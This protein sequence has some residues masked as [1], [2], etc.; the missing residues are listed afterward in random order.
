VE[1]PQPRK[2]IAKVGYV[3]ESKGMSFEK[4]REEPPQKCRK[5]RAGVGLVA[6]RDS[7]GE[8]ECTLRVVRG[9]TVY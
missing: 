5:M 1:E 7:E 3:E 6:G 4:V 8:V 9:A 2:S